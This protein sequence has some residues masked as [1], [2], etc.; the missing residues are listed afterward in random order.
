MKSVMLSIRPKWCELI[1]TGKKT[2]EVRKTKP[3]IATPFKCYIYMTKKENRVIEEK[4]GCVIE[5]VFYI[6]GTVVGEFTCDDISEIHPHDDG[7]GV[8]QYIFDAPIATTL[9]GDLFNPICDQTCL[10]FT[11]LKQYLGE[12]TGYSWHISNLVVYDKP[13][14][15]SDFGLKRPFQSWGYVTDE[16]V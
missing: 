2:V 14:A 10:S 9:H 15:L 8:N 3:N 7:Y 12:K 4:N 6:A 1:A 5:Q 13:K 16:E 11:E